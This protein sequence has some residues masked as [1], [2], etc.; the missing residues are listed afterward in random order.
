MGKML[1]GV[2]LV[3][4]SVRGHFFMRLNGVGIHL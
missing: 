3:G 1:W 2:F 4:D